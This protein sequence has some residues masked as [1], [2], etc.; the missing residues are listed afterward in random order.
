MSLTPW[1]PAPAFKAPSKV[2]PAFSFDNVAGRYMLLAF[3]PDAGPERDAALKL[4]EDNRPHFNDSTRLFFGVLPDRA[5][6]D[7]AP[8]DPPWRWF[9]DEDGD[10]RRL[11]HAVDADGALA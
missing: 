11:Y 10:L 6:L 1:T 9:L 3:L 7:A 5:S 8:G 2:N 4:I